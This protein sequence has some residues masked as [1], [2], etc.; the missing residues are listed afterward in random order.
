VAEARTRPAWV[1]VDL[2]ALTH[3]VGVLARLVAPA[4]L[5]AVVKADAYGHGAVPVA[6]AAVASGATRL[7]VA[8]VDEGVELREQGVDVP[9]LVLSEPAPDAFEPLV[10]AGLTATVTT[11]R[12]FEAL[13]AAACRT[14]TGARAHVKVDT[15]MHRVG[16]APE[17]VATLL[18]SVRAHAPVEVE[19]LWTHFAVADGTTEEDRTFTAHQLERFQ[20]V[21]AGLPARPPLLHAANTAGAL[22]W[23]AARLDMVRCGIGM[24]G[25]APS[26]AMA[27][28]AG[29][30][31]A[32]VL[33]CLRPALS[34][35][36]RVSEV[37]ELD[38]GAR[39][40][41]GRRRPL[42]ERSV[43]ATVPVG[44]ADGVPRRLFDAGGTV[45]VSGRRCPLA[46]VVTMDQL[47]VDCG[48]GSAVAS[49]DE[50]V[51]IGRQGTEEV[52]A[53]D[54]AR[55]LG[56]ISYE[57]LCGIGARVPRVYTGGRR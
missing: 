23:P 6:R 11:R 12:G 10:Q 1:E 37:R 26:P 27:E 45:L 52:T 33:A 51:L 9:V 28:G 57:V 50:V 48:P 25:Y 36:A 5:C 8:V 16:A 24:Y 43:V 55:R 19:G 13:A 3:N 2:D 41:Y 34:F 44:Y 35:K 17:E 29:P 46:G 22:A 31:V 53:E 40:S 18:G 38:A 4:E 39:P 14:R 7:A 54:W 56:T 21:V 32:S 15:G 49:G 47:L 20:Q 42:P 30:E